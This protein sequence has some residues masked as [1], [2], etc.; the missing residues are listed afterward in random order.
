[1]DNVLGK[2][3][4]LAVSSPKV[5]DSFLDWKKKNF[6]ISPEN[7]EQLYFKNVIDLYQNMSSPNDTLQKDFKTFVN[8]I[9]PLFKGTEHYNRLLN[10]NY[11]DKSQVRV[12]LP[13][14]VDKIQEI[15]VFYRN[16]RKSL[17]HDKMNLFVN[18]TKG[19]VELVLRNLLNDLSVKNPDDS[20]N[21]SSLDLT[22]VNVEFI[23]LYDLYD[24][25]NST[26]SFVQN[27]EIL[28]KNPIFFNIVDY[29]EKNLNVEYSDY[30]NTCSSSTYDVE[31]KIDLSQE[32]SSCFLKYLSG[33]EKMELS[34]PYEL[35]LKQGEN[36]FHWISGENLFEK[37]NIAI[38]KTNIHS[39]DWSK[40]TS[41]SNILS[42]DI[43]FV[44]GPEG[45]KA[46]WFKNYDKEQ[47]NDSMVCEIR[48]NLEFRF[49]FSD[50]GLSGHGFDWTG[51]N[52]KKPNID[53]QLFY[54]SDYVTI[55][56]LIDSNYWSLS[57]MSISSSDDI[58]LNET[59]L[60]ENGAYASDNYESAD[61]LVLRKNNKDDIFDGVYNDVETR[62]W[63]YAF[64]ETEIPIIPGNN[65]IYWP[66][67]R[68]D[69]VSELFLEY[70]SGD[71][72]LLSSIDVT[73]Q[74]LGAIASD[75]ISSA[76]KIFRLKTY[77]GP[78]IECAWLRGIPLT[79][80]NPKTI[81]GCSCDYDTKIVPTRRIYSDGVV[82]NYTYFKATPNEFT[83]FN[84][85]GLG[86]KG[87]ILL[88]DIPSFRGF[89]HDSTCQ[90]S[91]M[92][93][94]DLLNVSKFNKNELE[95]N[96]WKKCNCKAIKYSPFGHRGNVYSDNG[97]YADFIVLNETPNKPFNFMTWK[98]SDGKDFKTSKDFA[99]FK[100]TDSPDKT[101]GWGKG[102]WVT[103][104]GTEMELNSLDQ[105]L[106]YRTSIDRC[107]GYQAPYGIFKHAFCSC[108]Y[109]DDN[110]NDS[111]CVPVW[112]KAEKNENGEW[113]D[114]G[115]ISD[116]MLE[117]NN[118]Y[119]YEHQEKSDYSTQRLLISGKN[120]SS[121]TTYEMSDGNKDSVYF[122]NKSDS[123]QGMNFVWNCPINNTKPF[124][125]DV[126]MNLS[127]TMIN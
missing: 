43:V 33:F 4:D 32:Y 20:Q 3:T 56:K 87:T 75:S 29:L 44:D 41:S 111:N 101:I 117:S 83:S 92:M 120:V 18:G 58:Y 103:S 15:V 49:P 22:S 77:C 16:K 110:C 35:N 31:N 72:V 91:K 48:N 36:F 57:T 79:S 73:E 74:F 81:D 104:A 10:L 98:G 113:I 95:V 55:T 65:N 100:L 34:Y 116:M 119:R 8:N 24:Y 60:A 109:H 85:A 59:T 1:M 28:S 67:G 38:L 125:T 7:T 50:K 90:Y 126:N 114:S 97:S 25:Y 26:D 45:K 112:M 46:A 61:K 62:A 70:S 108:R 89:E 123:Y 115:K 82:Q 19:S 30:G 27:F 39:L 63:L 23:Q 80:I 37:S 6:S 47:V 9:V 105:Y 96:Q 76:D 40:A 86:E 99:W 78:D 107:E 17:K 11:D 94:N 84:L 106:Y 54:G 2:Y 53:Y 52:I 64:K 68:F 13:L 12:I 122:E 14:I 21:M 66:L 88:N 42:S 5:E 127:S 124:W 93:L 102:K 51:A 121:P 118:F 71:S 69:D